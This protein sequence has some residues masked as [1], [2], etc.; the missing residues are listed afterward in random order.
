LIKFVGAELTEI[1]LLLPKSHKSHPVPL[2]NY[3]A[4]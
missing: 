4:L 2:I 1:F 3:R